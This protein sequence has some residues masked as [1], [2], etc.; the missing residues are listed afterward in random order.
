MFHGLQANAAHRALSGFLIFFLAFLLREHPMAGQSAA[1]SLAIVGVSAGV[2]NACGTAV[3]AWLRAR[4]PEVIIATVLGLALGTAVLAAVFFSTAAVA[5][6][7]RS[8]GS[9]RPSPS[10]RWTR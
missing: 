2:G 9:P 7:G 10:C 1:V 3:G 4:G 5:A 6:L 8:P